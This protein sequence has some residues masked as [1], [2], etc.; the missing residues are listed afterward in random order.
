MFILL[1]NSPRFASALR[2]AGHEVAVLGTRS[3][4]EI[5]LQPAE[6]R[7]PTLLDRLPRLPDALI[8]ELFGYRD[9]LLGLADVDI[10]CLAYVIDTQLNDYWLRSYAPLLD[11]VLLDDPE[12]ALEYREQG[13]D[14]HYF[15]LSVDNDLLPERVPD[16]RKE[17]DIV[18][19]GRV[20]PE[21]SKRKA[22]LEAI[23]QHHQIHFAGGD[24][25]AFIQPREMIALFAKSRVVL[26]ENLFACWTQ[27]MFDGMASGSALFSERV[28][29]EKGVLALEHRHFMPFGP[30]DLL[31]NLGELLGNGDLRASLAEEGQAEILAKH[32]HQHRADELIEHISA[33]KADRHSRDTTAALIQEA[34]AFRLAMLQWPPLAQTL[35]EPTLN[36]LEAALEVEEDNADLLRLL[37]LLHR[38]QREDEVLANHYLTAAHELAPDRLDISVSLAESTLQFGSRELAL[39]ILAP[40][41]TVDL[42][43]ENDVNRLMAGFR[44]GIGESMVRKGR[45]ILLG[46]NS[47]RARLFPQDANVYFQLAA[48]LGDAQAHWRACQLAGQSGDVAG[49]YNLGMSLLGRVNLDAERIFQIGKWA[50]ESYL[51]KEADT[52]MRYTLQ[53]D[54]NLADSVADYLRAGHC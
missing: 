1:L 52:L 11:R 40:W 25:N 12:I 8:L 24:G 4:C 7:W 43:G 22:L 33:T 21:R 20:T 37:G 10:P 32:T 38:E 23:S 14:A 2:E 26:N 44:R 15:P 34:E 16:S 41:V 27:R 45:S 53:Q 29:P 17:H 35:L 36:R 46:F 19:V 6:L 54:P 48:E 9:F 30:F 47:P 49:A 42:A 50:F 13:I 3:D 18:F 28:P 31:Q 39:Q 5:K 51:Y